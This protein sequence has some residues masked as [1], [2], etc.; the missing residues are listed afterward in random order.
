MGRVPEQLLTNI[1]VVGAFALDATGI[2]RY[3]VFSR[4]SLPRSK[5]A[6]WSHGSLCLPWRNTLSATTGDWSRYRAS[7]DGAH[8]E[9]RICRTLF[10]C[11]TFSC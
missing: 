8:W 2:H 5:P 4:V 6:G 11:R 10:I 7:L 3:S 9:G 1:I